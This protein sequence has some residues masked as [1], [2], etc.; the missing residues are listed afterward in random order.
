MKKVSKAATGLCK[1]VVA[2]EAYDRVA[3]V[4]APKKELL[5]ES[6]ATLAI[7]MDQLNEKKKAL[8]D[9]Q[10]ELKQIEEKH[11]AATKEKEELAEKV[12]QCNIQLRRAKQLIDSLG[13]E[14]VRWTKLVSQLWAKP[15]K[16]I[17]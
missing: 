16:D 7:K 8:G 15:E 13:G 3:K 4:V 17:R 1:W 6:E 2:M 5:K 11:A 12:N 9:V 10:D 14:T